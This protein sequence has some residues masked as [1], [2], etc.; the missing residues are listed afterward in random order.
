[1]A[2]VIVCVINLYLGNR[3][4]KDMIESA[5]VASSFSLDFKDDF[6]YETYLLIVENKTIE[7]SSIYKLL[8]DANGIVDKLFELTDSETDIAILESARQYLDNLQKYIERIELNLATGNRYD[9]NLLIWEND[10]Q[11]VTSLISETL[12]EY[13]FNE[14]RDIQETREQV[15]HNSLMIIRITVVVAVIL[16]VVT[17][18]FSVVIPRSILR[19]IYEIR[20]VTREVAGGNMSMRTHIEYGGEVRDLGESLNRMID[21]IEELLD[22]VTLEQI[23]LRHAELELL[24]AQINPHF[25]Y[26][27]LDTIV[28][29]AETGDQER[30]V[31]MVGSLSNFFRT[32]LNQGKDNI[33]IGEELRH[34]R[35]YLEIQQVRYQ[36]ILSYEIDVPEEITDRIIPKITI[37]PLVENALYHGIKNKRGMGHIRITGEAK[38]GEIL[39]RVSDDGIGMTAE[40]LDTVRESIA[41]QDPDRGDLYGLYNVN[42]RIRL[43]A[44]DG[45]GISL[46]SAYGEGT[47]VTITLPDKTV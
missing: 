17:I 18:I 45:Y 34:A 43:R 37:Q 44:G 7:E 1:M 39:L 47:V 20:D 41:H 28:W 22:T 15:E 13:I 35:S 36:D 23:R 27:T 14:I 4:Y 12:N 38:D 31:S 42:E 46:D 30:V 11:I 2:L 10:V 16:L 25:L 3:R 26:N 21:K 8:D 24:Q 5:V 9:E 6:D 40:R 32:S 33:S 29:L 19:P